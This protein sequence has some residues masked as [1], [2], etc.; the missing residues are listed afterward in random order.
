MPSTGLPHPEGNPMIP[1]LMPTVI[2]CPIHVAFIAILLAAALAA[3]SG[4][5][6]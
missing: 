4:G 5:L 1:L 6:L 3:V 2:V